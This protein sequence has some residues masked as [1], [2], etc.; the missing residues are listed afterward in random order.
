VWSASECFQ[1]RFHGRGG[2]GVVTAAELLSVAAFVEGHYSQAFPTFGSERAGAPIMAFC[3]ISNREIRTRSPI[4]VPD[5]LIVQDPTL[6]HQ[7][8]LFA[9]FP[10]HGWALVNTTRLV[11][12]LA[13]EKHLARIDRGHL[14]TVGATDLALRH[15]GRPVPNAVLLGGF[16]AMFDVVSLDSVLK[17]IEQRFSTPVAKANCAAAAEAFE[18]VAHEER[19]FSNASPD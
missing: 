3:R 8:D 4:T 1:V 16:A 17:A 11:E 14:V 6:L 10:A 13:R 19:E 7:P 18:I 15:L 2:Q 5:A 12:D 9:G